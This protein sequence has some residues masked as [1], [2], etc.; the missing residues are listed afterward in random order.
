[1]TRVGTLLLYKIRFFFGPTL[2]GRLGPLA[3]LG[4]ILLF[5]PSGYGIGIAL[6]TGIRGATAAQAISTLSAPLSAILALGFLYSLFSGVTAHVSEFDFFMTADVRPR[7]YLLADLLFQFVSLFGAGGLAAVVAAFGMVSFI[8]R[9]LVDV[10]PLLLTLFAFALLVLM[11]IQIVTVLGV[12]YPKGHV[13]TL[14]L[15]L[16]VLSLLPAA[17]LAYPAFPLHFQDLPLPTTAFGTLGYDVLMG[18][19]L[20]LDAL[21]IALVSFLAVAG[22]WLAVSDTY[23]FHGIHPSLSAGFGQVDMAARMAQ[24]RR[25]TAGFGKF[26]TGLTVRTD[27]GTDTSYMARYHLLRIVRDGSIVFIALFAIISLLPIQIGNTQPATAQAPISLLAT[28]MLTFLVAILALNWSYYERDNLWIVLAAA[29]SPAPYFR[30]L[31]MS[32]TGVGLIVAFAFVLFY[33]GTYAGPIPVSELAVPIAAAV[34]AALVSTALLTRVKV[35]PSAFSFAMIAILFCAVVAG[36]LGG[37]AASGILVAVQLALGL[38]S[39]VQVVVLAAYC[40][41]LAG[42]GLWWV[43]RLAA[44]F[45][46]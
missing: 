39:G 46:L 25:M 9:P 15:M 29:K 2:R 36:Y 17:T 20:S 12:R 26:T 37:F 16:F 24:Q 38:G 34:S 44:G 40:G 18:L 35:Q 41:A 42:F 13:R 33:L 5:L 6:A 1:M 45:R 28:Q 27:R 4:M 31:M 32:F 10:A 43:S 11:V 19:P 14:A 7:E 3:Y 30:G 23:I 8:G 22:L 21:A